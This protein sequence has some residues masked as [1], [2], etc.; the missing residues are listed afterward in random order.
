M[1]G[2]V[3]IQDINPGPASSSYIAPEKYAW[4]TNVNN[5]LF[6]NADNGVHGFE[7]WALPTNT[8]FLPVIQKDY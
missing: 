1:T 2:T 4:L 5:R 6:F 8:I 3:M 7:L